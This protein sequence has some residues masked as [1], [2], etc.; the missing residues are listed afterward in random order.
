MTSRDG[1]VRVEIG[2]EGGQIM[3]ALVSAAAAQ[4]LEQ[5]LGRGEE[6]AFGLEAEDG[7]YTVVLRRVDYLKRFAREARVGFGAAAG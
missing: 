7:R 5:A 4:E 3:S 1:R 2:F 6:G